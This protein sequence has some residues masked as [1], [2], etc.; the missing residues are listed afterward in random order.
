MMKINFSKFKT[1]TAKEIKDSPAME[2]IADGEIIGILIIGSQGAM[3]EKVKG[4]A[5]QID[6]GRGK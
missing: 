3:T 4:I 2:I 6:A 5:S 1:M